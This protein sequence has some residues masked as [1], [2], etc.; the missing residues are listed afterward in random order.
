MCIC[1]C[2]CMRVSV[3]MCVCVCLHDRES[4]YSFLN[5]SFIA[6]RQNWSKAYSGNCSMN[7]FAEAPRGPKFELFLLQG[8]FCS[9][10]CKVQ[11]ST[12]YEV[13]SSFLKAL[14]IYRAYNCHAEKALGIYATIK[15]NQ[16]CFIFQA[17]LFFIK[18]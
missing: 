18:P 17:E 14:C 3:C 15:S 10:S 11:A 9:R 6:F 4:K 7:Y 12:L 16:L 2:A 5:V 1:V 13:A 8:C